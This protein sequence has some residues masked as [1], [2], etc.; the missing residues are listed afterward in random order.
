MKYE[1]IKDALGID[2]WR[3]EAIDPQEGDCYVA[4]F[5]GPNAKE[6]AEEYADFENAK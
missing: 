6:R 3:C 1:V 2:M 5:S 4:I